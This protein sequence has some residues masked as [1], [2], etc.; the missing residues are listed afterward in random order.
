MIHLTWGNLRDAGFG[1][2]LAKLNDKPMGLELGMRV[3]IIGREI[4]KQRE[5]ASETHAGILKKYGKPSPTSPGNFDLNPE[6]RSEYDEEMKK[7]DKQGFSVKVAKLAASFVNEVIPLTPQDL[8]ALEPMLE[9][10]E[11]QETEKQSAN[12]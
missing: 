8:M 12:P 6:T 9:I 11:S 3:A 4:K 10:S 7:F 5:L 1:Q 2:A